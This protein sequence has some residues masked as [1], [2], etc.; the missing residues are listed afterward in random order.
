MSRPEPIGNVGVIGAW[1][2]ETT[3]ESSRLQ[4]R[5]Q[6]FL[7]S[8]DH[9]QTNKGKVEKITTHNRSDLETLGSRPLMP[10]K[11]PRQWLASVEEE[12]NDE[13]EEQEESL[14]HYITS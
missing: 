12:D 1:V 11:S 4:K 3:G 7:K 10:K 9:P 5:Y 6:S 14:S 8:T 13:K 2:C